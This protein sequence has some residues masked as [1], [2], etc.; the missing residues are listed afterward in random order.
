MPDKK[1]YDIAERIGR[2]EAKLDI[3]HKDSF[4]ITLALIGIIAANIG[5][6]VVGS[7]PLLDVLTYIT[8]FGSIVV[9]GVLVLNWKHLTWPR[10]ILRI[11]LPITMIYIWFCQAFLYSPGV[12]PAP[13]WFSPI[14]QVFMIAILVTIIISAWT[15]K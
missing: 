12:T 7:P 10:R 15:D 13:S 8:C 14:F 5:V 4:K 1:E 2:I 9:L 11:L 6:K 3:L